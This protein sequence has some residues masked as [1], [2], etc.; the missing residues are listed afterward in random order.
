MACSVGSR[1]IYHLTPPMQARGTFKWNDWLLY[2]TVRFGFGLYALLQVFLLNYWNRNSTELNSLLDL[3]V[4]DYASF[5]LNR[6]NFNHSCSRYINCS[7][8]LRCKWTFSVITC[9][10]WTCKGMNT[11]SVS[12]SG[13]IRV[14]WNALLRSPDAWKSPPPLSSVTMHSNGPWRCRWRRRSVCL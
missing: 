7:H 4:D 14:H 8:N 1:S 9:F 3:C 5:S 10:Y 6:N 13:S 2:A 11:P 12:G